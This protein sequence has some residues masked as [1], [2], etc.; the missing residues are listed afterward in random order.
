LCQS[1][2]KTAEVKRWCC[3][4]A[5][6]DACVLLQRM[7]CALACSRLP[8]VELQ[9]VQKRAI[10]QAQRL[11]FGL[12]VLLTCCV[13]ASGQLALRGLLLRYQCSI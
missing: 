3:V 13:L 8:D 9:F 6:E 7:L 1:W 4:L 2:L 5:D 11:C 10:T 12:F